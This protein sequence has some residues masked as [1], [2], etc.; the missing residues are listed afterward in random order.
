M[1]E[2][3]F[4]ARWYSCYCNWSHH[5]DE[6][7]CQKI[8]FEVGCGMQ[9]ELTRLSLGAHRVSDVRNFDLG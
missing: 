6:I 4:S 8:H 9:D 5:I 2:A 3:D 7:L 1:I